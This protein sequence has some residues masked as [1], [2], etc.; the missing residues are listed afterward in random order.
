MK[1]CKDVMTPN[2]VCCMPDETVQQVALLMKLENVGSIPVVENRENNELIGILTDRDLTLKVIAAG[3]DPTKTI[4]REVMKH[5]PFTCLDSD[6][7]KKAFDVM[8]GR[9]VRRI[10]VLDRDHRIVGIISQADMAKQVHEPEIVAEVLA[11]ISQ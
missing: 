11:K 7:S 5:N 6:D 9:K 10:P 1:T 4:I 3:K 2:P 8:A